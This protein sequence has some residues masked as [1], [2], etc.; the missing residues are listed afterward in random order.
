M[1]PL[2]DGV[3]INDH[4]N[5]LKKR[6]CVDYPMGSGWARR[7][8]GEDELGMRTDARIIVESTGAWVQG[9]YIIW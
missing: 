9:E 6:C 4:M 1:H 2:C 5:I 3:C 7:A 8:L